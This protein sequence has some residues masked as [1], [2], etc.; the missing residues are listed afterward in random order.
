MSNLVKS[1][2]RVI[3][4]LELLA[5]VTEGMTLSELCIA[6]LIPASSMHALVNTLI[7]KG[8][9]LKDEASQ[10]YLLGPKLPQITA[11]FNSHLDLTSIADPYMRHLVEITGESTFVTRLDRDKITILKVHPGLGVIRIFNMVGSHL[12]AHATGS[13]K[14]QLA[15]LTE[16][17][18]DQIY[19]NEN[20]PAILPATIK[21]KTE[22]K[23]ALHLI[24]EA[25]Y[26]LD[27]EEA[28]AGVWAM[29][30]CI[31]DGSGRPMASLSISAP[32]FR[33]RR[34]VIGEWAKVLV[35]SALSI[36]ERFGFN[37]RSGIPHTTTGLPSHQIGATVK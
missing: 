13:G 10:R 1:A 37:T 3:D 30:S 15:Y 2:A 33:V 5:D 32:S 8:Y 28:E 4:I 29:A 18:V 36:S 7:A 11:I 26:A 17:E 24:R 14:A 20:L 19:P 27:E 6:L 35:Q 23:Q 9:L 12:P 34:E 21:T 25:G 31:R 16:A 22:L